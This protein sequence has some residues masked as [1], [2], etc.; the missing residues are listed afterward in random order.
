MIHCRIFLT[1][2]G[3]EVAVVGNTQGLCFQFWKWNIGGAFTS[4]WVAY[5]SMVVAVTFPTNNS[6]QNIVVVFSGD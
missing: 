3:V 1:S 4:G 5:I 2:L 6:V